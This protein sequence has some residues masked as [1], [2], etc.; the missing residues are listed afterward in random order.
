MHQTTTNIPP[1]TVGILYCRGV[2]ARLHPPRAH[3]GRSGLTHHTVQ[4]VVESWKVARYGCRVAL[5]A[6]S[7]P[8]FF[9]EEHE[10]RINFA[11]LGKDRIHCCDGL[12]HAGFV[13]AI[14]HHMLHRNLHTMIIGAARLTV[15]Y[16][17]SNW[18][19]FSWRGLITRC[20]HYCHIYPS[21]RMLLTQPAILGCTSKN[22]RGD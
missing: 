14:L 4:Q 22:G 15:C 3:H 1:K 21:A 13:L 18:V 9:R 6:G 19:S 2:Y 12:R 8:V 11:A 5:L 16:F 10:P 20:E 17:S 7:E